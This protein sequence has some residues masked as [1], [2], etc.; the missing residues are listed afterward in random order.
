[1]IQVF[2]NLRNTI[3]WHHLGFALELN[4]KGQQLIHFS[5]CIFIG[6]RFTFVFF[7][8]F[9]IKEN[10]FF[11]PKVIKFSMK[12][13]PKFLR[14]ICQDKIY[15]WTKSCNKVYCL[16][17]LKLQSMSLNTIMFSIYELRENFSNAVFGQFHLWHKSINWWYII[18]EVMHLWDSLIKL[19]DNRISYFME[20][21]KVRYD[22]RI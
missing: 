8:I 20:G 2:N 7:L 9:R 16:F 6:D 14:R 1:M 12:T 15:G 10:V 18:H 11:C 13:L 19:V 5:S 3:D 17:V 4:L 22:Q 21:T